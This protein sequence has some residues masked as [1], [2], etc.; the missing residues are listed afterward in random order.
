MIPLEHF[1]VIY[2]CSKS[3]CSWVQLLQVIVKLVPLIFST[4]I[5]PL[6]PPPAE[7]RK[8]D[9]VPRLGIIY[10]AI[11]SMVALNDPWPFPS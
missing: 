11:A 2:T 8:F 5:P 1:V 9:L 4:G 7:G 3:Y 6:I 10:A